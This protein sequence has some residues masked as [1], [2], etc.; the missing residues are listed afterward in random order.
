VFRPDYTAPGVEGLWFASETFRSR[1]IGVDR[2]A[3]AGLT[4]VEQ[5]L[6]KRIPEFKESWHD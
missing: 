4:C 2:A 1:G 6:G 3:R 5:I